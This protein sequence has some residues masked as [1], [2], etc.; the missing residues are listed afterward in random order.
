M[1]LYKI[2]FKKSVYKDLRGISKSIVP[3][4]IDEIELLAENLFPANSRQLVGATKT[5]RIRIGDYRVIYIVDSEDREI[6]IQII[7]HRKD[8]YR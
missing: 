4:I 5:Y 6:E 1:G 8:V 7:A 3:K 2:N